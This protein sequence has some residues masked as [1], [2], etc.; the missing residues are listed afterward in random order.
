MNARPF[1][2]EWAACSAQPSISV[3]SR[4]SATTLNSI[5]HS[6]VNLSS[7]FAVR[8]I[9]SEG[10]S[11]TDLYLVAHHIAMDGISMS[12]LSTEL[13]NF[14][15]DSTI[16]QGGLSNNFHIAH[17]IE[18]RTCLKD[19]TL[20][21]SHIYRQHTTHPQH[22]KLQRIFGLLS[23]SQLYPFSGRNHPRVQSQ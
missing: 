8:W 9:I 12:V 6:A 13:H 18:V 21:N 20:T 4:P 14:V 16:P 10:N 19:A 1:V 23:A 22:S 17:M 5:L 11:A 15:L 2:A 7:Q 3:L